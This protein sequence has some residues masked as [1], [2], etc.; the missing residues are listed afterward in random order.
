MYNNR[1]K[2]K[3]TLTNDIKFSNSFLARA[4]EHN[5]NNGNFRNGNKRITNRPV[6]NHQFL[7]KNSNKISTQINR[8]H[9]QYPR[10]STIIKRPSSIKSNDSNVRNVYDNGSSNSLQSLSRKSKYIFDLPIIYANSDITSANA[11]RIE[12]KDSNEKA[13]QMVIIDQIKSLQEEI[14]Y[15]YLKT[16][17][18]ESH[19][20]EQNRVLTKINR[21]LLDLT[22]Y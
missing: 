2:T 3:K 20:A 4:N 17:K 10:N 22:R 15:L 16:K 8:N 5:N 7:S 21:V 6:I 11:K 1:F 9:I 12:H 18:L 14:N 13:F 19:I